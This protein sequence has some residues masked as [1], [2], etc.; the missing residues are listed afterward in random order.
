MSKR[1]PDRTALTRVGSTAVRDDRSRHAACE[2]SERC[3]SRETEDGFA[4]DLSD[5]QEALEIAI[6]LIADLGARDAVAWADGYMV[7]LHEKGDWRGMQRWGIVVSALD[8]LARASV[9]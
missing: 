9:H 3:V 8:E 1:E 2:A 7:G 6:D 4:P 5:Q